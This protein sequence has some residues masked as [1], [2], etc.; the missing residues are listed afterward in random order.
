MPICSRNVEQL[1]FK[2]G[3]WTYKMIKFWKLAEQFL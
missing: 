2:G 3:K 1:S